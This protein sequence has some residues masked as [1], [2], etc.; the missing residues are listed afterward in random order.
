MNTAATTK[1]PGFNC[2]IAIR[3][4]TDKNGRKVAQRWMRTTGFG[5]WVKVSLVDAEL[6]LAQ[7]LADRA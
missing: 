5:R 7:D 4:I 3:F 2:R 1:T 6:W